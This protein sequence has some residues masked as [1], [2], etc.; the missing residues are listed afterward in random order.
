[1]RIN[2]NADLGES[3]GTWTMGDDA[4]MLAIVDSANIACGAHAGDPNVMRRTVHLAAANR[5]SLGAHPSFPD[6]QG[7]G[8]RAMPMSATELEN[9]IAFQVGALAGIAALEAAHLTHIKPHGALNNIACG[10]RA[11]ADTICR[12]IKAIDQNLILLAPATSQLVAAGHAAGLKVIEEIFADRAYQ[13]N[14]ELLPRSQPGAVLHDAA[15]C[16]EHVLAILAA[17]ALIAV[18]GS[19]LA[20]PIG[21]ICVHGDNPH[22]VDVARAI[23]HALTE[24]G[25]SLLPLT[26]M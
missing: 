6:L 18:D 9:Q 19:R 25:H 2:L 5:V 23:R 13:A 16:V 24:A 15:E 3:F 21:S 26:E 17:G 20:T 10:D 1:M 7:F 4:A 22:A 8:R 14:G 12:S 11:V